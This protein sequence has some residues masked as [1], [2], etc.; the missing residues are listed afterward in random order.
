M[1]IISIKF[2]D[3]TYK[4]EIRKIFANG[5]QFK[6]KNE[7]K[8]EVLRQWTRISPRDLSNHVESMTD[9]ILDVIKKDGGS[10]KY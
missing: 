4:K 10:T 8:E 1:I 7:L 3:N 5:K 2:S 6:N 9:R